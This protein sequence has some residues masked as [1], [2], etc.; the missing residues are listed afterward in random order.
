MA[1]HNKQQMS[2]TEAA[3]VASEQNTQSTSQTKVEQARPATILSSPTNTQGSANVQVFTD[4]LNAFVNVQSSNDHSTKIVNG[5]KTSWAERSV[6]AFSN[7]MN[8]VWKNQNDPELL[9]AC[10]KA[11]VTYRNSC[12][13]CECA[14]AGFNYVKSQALRNRLSVMHMLMFELTNTNRFRVD[15]DYDFAV[16]STQNP[17][18]SEPNGFVQYCAARMR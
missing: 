17:A 10:R 3:A 15:Y 6:T 8:F 9:N 1:N 11:F 12:L 4:L 5:R 18:C 14:M 16:S 7:M 13:S 2:A